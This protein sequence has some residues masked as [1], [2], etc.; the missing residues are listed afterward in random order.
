M[1]ALF[2][3]HESQPLCS[4]EGFMMIT[5]NRALTWEPRLDQLG[6]L[7]QLDQLDQLD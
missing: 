3:L 1:V 6:L 5:K 2:L 4:V 7:D